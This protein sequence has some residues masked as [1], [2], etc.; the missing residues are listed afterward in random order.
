MILE[1]LALLC[2]QGAAAPTPGSS[3]EILGPRV[4]RT[5]VAGATVTVESVPADPTDPNRPTFAALVRVENR[6]GR[7]LAMDGARFTVVLPPAREDAAWGLAPPDGSGEAEVFDRPVAQPI[8]RTI[9][10]VPTAPAPWHQSTDVWTGPFSSGTLGRPG[11]EAG[12]EPATP[13]APERWIRE[14]LPER[15]MR[16]G[17]AAE[18]FLFFRNIGTAGTSSLPFELRFEL[19]DALTEESLGDVRVPLIT[20][21]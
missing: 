12:R 10:E 20:Q 9:A 8:P 4:A 2:L 1:L 14:P 19:V 18:G 13:D 7:T 17:L 16:D 3:V 11:G 5:T 15:P 21:P 6:T